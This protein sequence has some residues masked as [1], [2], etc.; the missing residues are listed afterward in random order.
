MEQEIWKDIEGFEGV[1]QVSSWGRV[2]SCERYV[3][4][5]DGRTRVVKEKILTPHRNRCGYLKIDLSK[6][7]NHK[8]YSVHRLVAQAFIPNPEN[9]PCVNHKNE[10]KDDNRVENLEF[11]TAKY[12]TNYGTCIQRR[13]ES[14]SKRIYQLSRDCS[15]IINIWNSAKEVEQVLG[16]Q[17]SHI[18]QCANGKRKSAHNYR[19]Q[20]ADD[21]LK[22]FRENK[23][24]T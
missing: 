1:Y 7:K 13:S 11:C 24:E 10:V 9:L 14:N 15:E 8:S 20:Y 19:W 17:S 4:R 18:C 16:W 3:K 12:N 2:K 21:M 22:P 5:S 6:E 23:S